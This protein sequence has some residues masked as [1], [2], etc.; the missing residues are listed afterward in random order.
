MRNKFQ[1]YLAIMVVLVLL[2]TSFV[3]I[4]RPAFAIHKFW[5]EINDHTPGAVNGFKFHFSI[6]KLLRVHEYIK[7]IFPPGTTYTIP[8][9]RVPLLPVD[10][11]DPCK[12]CHGIPIINDLPDGSVELK[13][14]THIELDPSKAG[15]RDIAVSI[16]SDSPYQ[17]R[18][19]SI[20]GS[21]VYKIATQAEPKLIVSY[22]VEVFQSFIS[23]PVLEIEP[24]KV[25]EI[26]GFSFDF[27]ISAFGG[28]DPKSEDKIRIR[29]PK[30]FTFTKSAWEFHDD[31][32]TVNENNI[33]RFPN[34]EH[35]NNDLIIVVPKEIKRGR[36]VTIKIDSRCGIK[37]PSSPG[38][39]RLLVS[40]TRDTEWISSSEVE[41]K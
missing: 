5:V 8:A 25:E 32:I 21:Y 31:W 26:A 28:L 34:I 16:P 19:P 6:E 3:V 22:P 40:T 41:V 14:N 36:N 23:K 2:I 29:F 4:V 1:K 27:K 35:N 10:P 13:Y 38:I 20:P 37:N 15:Y 30:E 7:I 17:F 18:T 33:S 39:Y 12:A 9:E 11:N 24:S